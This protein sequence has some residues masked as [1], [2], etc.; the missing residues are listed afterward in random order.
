MDQVPVTRDILRNLKNKRDEEMRIQ[1]V[2]NC[3]SQ[4]YSA[5]IQKAKTST[6]TSYYHMLPSFPV[7]KATHLPAPHPEFHRENMEDILHGLRTLFPDCSVE[8]STLIQG[9]DGKLYDISK[10][11]EK[12]MQFAFH[13]SYRKT[14]QE[15]IVIDWS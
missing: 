2:N 9:Q 15:Y 3:I 1:K 12:V 13:P 11:D 14:S 4:V 8:Y 10:M 7:S 5:I 6:E